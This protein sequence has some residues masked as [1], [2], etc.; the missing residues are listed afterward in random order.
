MEASKGKILPGRLHV[1]EEEEEE[2]WNV[3]WTAR[4]F[5]ASVFSALP[6]AVSTFGFPLGV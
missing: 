3:L 6:R 2:A 1:R 5:S 4:E